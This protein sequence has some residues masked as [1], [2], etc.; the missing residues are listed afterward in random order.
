MRV[1]SPTPGHEPRPITEPSLTPP[2]IT[3]PIPSCPHQRSTSRM[4]QV[5]QTLLF[6]PINT[7][8]KGGGV[9]GERAG[10]CM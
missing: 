10:A 6:I 1:G 2:T 4:R 5:S 8:V 7:A 3:T 9:C